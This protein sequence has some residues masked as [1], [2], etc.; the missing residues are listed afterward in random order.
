MKGIWRLSLAAAAVAAMAI[1]AVQASSHR[2]APLI[3]AGPARRQHRRLRVRQPERA[4]R[5][6]LIANFIPFEAP[7][8]GPNFF[9]F[10]DN[11]LYEIMVDNNGDA[12]EDVTFQF[13][14][15]H[16]R[17]Q[18]EHVPLQHRPDHLARLP[19]LERPPVLHA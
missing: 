8:G 7:Y 9:K 5:V 10:D 16:R 19:E 6:T 2:E 1:T 12:V 17:P 11:V 13:T 15:T 14:F 4:G 18:P 3:S